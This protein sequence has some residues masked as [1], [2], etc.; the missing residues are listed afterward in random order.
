TPLGAGTVLGFAKR[1]CRFVRL[2]HAAR[3]ARPLPEALGRGEKDERAQQILSVGRTASWRARGL[4]LG[5]GACRDGRVRADPDADRASPSALLA[6]RGA[7]AA[8]TRNAIRRLAGLSRDAGQL[9]R[10]SG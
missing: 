6:G 3:R 8:A 1:P 5:R 7:D 2:S 9:E 10:R 4:A